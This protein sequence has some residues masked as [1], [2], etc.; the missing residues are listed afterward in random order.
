[1]TLSQQRRHAVYIGT[2]CH[3]FSISCSFFFSLFL[4][5]LWNIFNLGFR[6][7][8][9]RRSAAVQSATRYDNDTSH[10]NG[11]Q[12]SY[13]FYSLPIS[14]PKF[15]GFPSRNG[16]QPSVITKGATC[17]K[18]PYVCIISGGGKGVQCLG[19]RER[20]VGVISIVR[21]DSGMLLFEFEELDTM[22]GLQEEW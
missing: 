5:L 7:I 10:K 13:S 2:R 15:H 11:E 14:P 18:F 4:F 1:M 9:Q 22:S 17:P 21:Q 12:I 6:K 16:V 20:H 8:P 3:H 19:G